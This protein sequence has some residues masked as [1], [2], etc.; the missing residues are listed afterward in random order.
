MTLRSESYTGMWPV[1][2]HWTPGEVRDVPDGY[3]GLDDALPEGLVREAPRDP[4]VTV[5][6]EPS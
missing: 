1:G 4:V 5:E 6:D 2:V 3:P